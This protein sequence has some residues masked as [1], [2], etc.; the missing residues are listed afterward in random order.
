[1]CWSGGT[2]GLNWW[3]TV[4][5]NGGTAVQPQGRHAAGCQ[6]GRG[7]FSCQGEAKDESTA[8]PEDAGSPDVHGPDAQSLQGVHDAQIRHLERLPAP[9]EVMPITPTVST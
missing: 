9:L 3:V 7:Q 4:P 8:E 6:P 2:S 1:M 5:T